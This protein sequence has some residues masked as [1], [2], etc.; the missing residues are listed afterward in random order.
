MKKCFEKIIT[1]LIILAAS[2]G[3]YAVVRLSI[4]EVK[5]A[6]YEEDAKEIKTDLKAIRCQLGDKVSCKAFAHE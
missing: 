2:T 3:A 5:Q 4:V 6:T 1:G